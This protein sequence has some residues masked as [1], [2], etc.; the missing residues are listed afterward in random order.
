MA[1]CDQKNGSLWKGKWLN[2]LVDIV[3]GDWKKKNGD[4]STKILWL[5]GMFW[6]VSD[7]IKK[8]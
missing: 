4:S 2:F 3:N 6:Y 8:W 5:D 7:K 1:G